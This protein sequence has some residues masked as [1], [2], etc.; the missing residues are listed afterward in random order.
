[1]D[2]DVK[3]MTPDELRAELR[4]LEQAELSDAGEVRFEQIANELA[5]RGE[6]S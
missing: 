6:P 3:T 1:M 2:R 5:R 4:S